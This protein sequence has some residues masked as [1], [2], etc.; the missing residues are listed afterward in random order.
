MTVSAF[1]FKKVRS[2]TLPL[3]KWKND[4]E[5]YYKIVSPM[6]KGQEISKTEYDENGVAKPKQE[7]VTLANV[8]DLETGEEGQIIIGAVLAETWNRDEQY[9]GEQYV[10]KSFAITQK[11]D[12]SKKYNTYTVIEIEVDETPSAPVKASKDK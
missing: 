11:R 9:A 7:P 6:F 1:K 10:G 3:L 5:R 12:P 4:V 2:V 8:I